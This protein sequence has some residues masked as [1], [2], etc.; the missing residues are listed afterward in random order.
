M[1]NVCGF[2]YKTAH[3]SDALVSISDSLTTIGALF[4]CIIFFVF[5]Q[6]A[7][8]IAFIGIRHKSPA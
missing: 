2:F 4:K 1:R 7:T 3:T 6:D 5:L 8:Y